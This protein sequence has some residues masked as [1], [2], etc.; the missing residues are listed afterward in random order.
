MTNFTKWGEKSE[1]RI[2][3]KNAFDDE[4]IFYPA[5]HENKQREN[6]I[7]PHQTREREREQ[8]QTSRITNRKAPA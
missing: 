8:Q 4:G 3:Y 2:R 5:R 7:K 6:K 1:N